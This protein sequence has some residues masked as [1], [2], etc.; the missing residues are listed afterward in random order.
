MLNGKK[1]EES[2]ASL[3]AI[4]END[5]MTDKKNNDYDVIVIG[6]GASGLL[7]AGMAAREGISVL[8]I[9]KMPKPAVKL[10]ITGKGRCNITN[11]AP[12]KEFITHFA[13]NGKFLWQPFSRFFSED[14][15]ELLRNLGVKTKTE[16]GGRVFPES[17]N[18]HQVAD[19]LA[20]FASSNGAR[21]LFNTTVKKII[22]ADNKVKGVKV[23]PKGENSTVIIYG[24]A[25][26]LATGGASYPGTG[27]SGDG[28]RIAEELGHSISPVSPALVP[29][30]TAGETAP[31]LQGLSLKNVRV[32]LWVDNK[33]KS[34]EFGDMLFT[35]S[36]ISGPVILS[37]SR[38]A[39]PYLKQKK[40]VEISID[41]KPALDN[42]KLDRRL[43]R[44]FNDHGKQQFKTILK[45]LLPR[46]L[47]PVCIEFS[48]IPPEKTAGQISAKER[49][50]LLRWLKDFRLII[51]GY[52]S[53]KEAIVTAG[54]V[55]VKEI[56]A[57]TM[58]SK[59]IKNL[60]FAGEV[61]DLDADTGGY[62]L[63]A[64]FS[65]GWLAGTS[66][67]HTIMHS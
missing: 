34:E 19:A 22:T 53:F 63:Q 64:A 2:A 50:R 16:R 60:F 31:R 67:S 52:G 14:L 46:K 1:N 5:V 21:F 20:E 55:S 30:F 56:E 3:T 23:L 43:L 28:Y 36:G 44:D 38:I 29:L 54:G 26:I 41:L 15:L 33:K 9:D 27:S 59:L 37:L 35:H 47:I 13:A 66:A 58:E 4:T 45:L 57:K 25:V 17:D 24:K 12:I 48:G 40:K 6:G 10:R 7:A 61:L 42:E 11:I 39:I 65:T 51:N 49:K 8:V 32:T 62:N 18:A